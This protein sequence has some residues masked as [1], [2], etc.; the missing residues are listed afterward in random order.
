MLTK[1]YAGCWALF[2]LAGLVLFLT[3]NFTMLVAVWFGFIA[4]G[5]VFMGMMGVLPA[6]ISHP[7]PVK[8]ENTAEKSA[9]RA[10]IADQ[11]QSY[12]HTLSTG[13]Q[14]PRHP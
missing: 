13:L 12:R 3:G 2:L 8:V 7:A 9:A 14:K 6:S 5:I 1:I 4:F 10:M 11:V